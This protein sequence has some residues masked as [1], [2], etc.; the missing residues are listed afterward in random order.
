MSD[1]TV[2]EQAEKD[3]AKRASRE[4]RLAR[5]RD[6]SR[7]EI[8]AAARRVLLSSGV[9]AMTLDAVATEAGMSKTGLYYYFRSKEALVFELVYGVLER[10]SRAVH[11]A[12]ERTVDGG[13]ALGAVIGATVD[14]F[15][16][17][18][19]DFRL[20]FLFGQVAGAGALRWDGEQFERIRPLNELLL[21]GATARLSGEQ[22][23]RAA[24]AAVEPRLMAFLAYLAALGLL[25]MKGMVEP[26][27]DPLL[28]TDEELVEGF[29]R[30]FEAAA[31]PESQ[32]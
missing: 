19:D 13:A 6:Q 9:A 17:Q 11:D 3:E 27:D 16:P 25:T 22:Q 23:G 24:R 21:A 12:V 31:A 1:E 14:A 7:V 4:A 26:M 8:L 28:Y 15:A 32:R 18:L 20:A 2:R 5:R 30:V 29:A 10:Q